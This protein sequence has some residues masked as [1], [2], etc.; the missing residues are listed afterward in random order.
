MKKRKRNSGSSTSSESS[1]IS[2]KHME[3]IIEKLKMKQNRDSTVKT[4]LSIWRQFNDFL[5][6]LD[7]MPRDWEDRASMFIAYLIEEKK[8]QS[9]SVKSYV[10]G[11]KKLLLIDGYNLK[12]ERILLATL[13]RA[14]KLVN[15]RVKPRLPIHCALL[16]ILLYE[17]DRMFANQPYLEILYKALFVLGYYGLMR[18]GELTH[19]TH[20]MK[21]R[22]V[23]LAVN[24]EK[25]L[26][27]LYTLKTHGQGS[28]PQEIK[29]TSNR[30]EKSGKYFERNFCPFKLLGKYIA[31]R[32]IYYKNELEEFFIFKDG[33]PVTTNHVRIILKKL[34]ANLGL[35]ADHYNT[36]SLRIG[37]ASD[38]IKYGYS[39][40]EVKRMGRWRSSCVYKYIR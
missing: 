4:Y 37:R 23:H 36:H 25:L 18:I 35:I 32:K 30:S 17:L 14:C 31:T 5:V 29:I 16:E 34:I 21:A 6:R 1:R 40:E 33:S 28:H 8:M 2:A 13:T 3:N 27:I 39:V 12:D 24:K 11:I 15:D 19:S 20:S 26:I 38:L 9:S 7:W 10:S 22:N